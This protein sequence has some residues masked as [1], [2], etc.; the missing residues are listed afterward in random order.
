M[1]VPTHLAAVLGGIL[2]VGLVGCADSTT[3]EPEA[4]SDIPGTTSSASTA[5]DAPSSDGITAEHNDA[6]VTFAQMMT[7]HHEGALEM[8]ALA[9]DMANSGDVKDL[10]ATIEAAQGPEIELMENW[11]KAWGEPLEPSGHEAMDHG[12]MDMNGMSQEQVMA[13]LQQ[14]SGPEFDNQFLTA[15][16]AHHEGAVMMAEEELQ[17]G[18]N[19]DA[20]ELAQRIIDAQETEIIQMQQLLE[21]V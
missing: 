11:L 12:G 19:A 13:E 10:A 18:E 21:D 16:I 17:A 6:D 1:N 20:L 2:L 4:T 7:I 15:M 14:T 8:S 9:V 5:P 3:A